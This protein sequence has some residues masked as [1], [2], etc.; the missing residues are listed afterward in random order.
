LWTWG[1]NAYGQLG[2]GTYVDRDVPVEIQAGSGLTWLKV[3][4]G[5]G[6]TVAI[7]S[8]GRIFTWGDNSLGQL[9]RALGATGE[10]CPPLPSLCNAA[11]PGEIPQFLGFDPWVSVTAGESHAVASTRNG[12][13]W[14]WGNNDFGQVGS[15][16]ALAVEPLPVL[17]EEYTRPIGGQGTEWIA[18]AAAGDHTLA[19]RRVFSTS[20]ATLWAWGRNDLGQVGDGT[21]VNRSRPLQIGTETNWSSVSAGLVHSFAVNSVGELWRWGSSLEGQLGI[22]AYG[23]SLDPVRPDTAAWRSGH[24]GGSHSVGI[25]QDGTLWTWG[26]NDAGQLGN[27]TII[28]RLVKVQIAP[29]TQWT[30][31]AAGSQHTLA[32]RLLDGRLLAWGE[33]D[34]GQLGDNTAWIESPLELK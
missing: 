8:D 9:G 19:I 10:Q 11:T 22:G 12:S 17:I 15:G 7:R 28:D 21:Q 30:T 25:M 29:G 32:V 31:A 24:G 16:T 23:I 14:A 33:N 34:K 6:H 2:D 20:M 13:L 27:G 3:S 18:V 5:A 4:A 26:R 1:S